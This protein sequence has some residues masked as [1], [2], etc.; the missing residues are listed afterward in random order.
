MRYNITHNDYTFAEHQLDDGWA[1]RLV[2]HYPGVL[3]QYGKVRVKILNEGTEEENAMLQF[4]F[5]IIDEGDFDLDELNNNEDFNNLLGEVLT[6]IVEDAFENG[7][8]KLGDDEHSNDNPKES[9][10]E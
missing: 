3:Y 1:V 7:K 9:T 2:N 6:H 4:E 8:Y 10:D 5:N